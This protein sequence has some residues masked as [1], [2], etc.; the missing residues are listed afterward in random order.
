MK[1][2]LI[3]VGDMSEHNLELRR[4]IAGRI[5]AARTARGWTQDQL[6]AELGLADRQ[7]ISAI[8]SGERRV[9][10][11]ELI[12]AMAVFAR[13]MEYFTDPAMIVEDNYFS[14]RA[15]RSTPD[16]VVFESTARKLLE[17]NRRLRTVLSEVVP[18]TFVGLRGLSKSSGIEDA[19]A[20]GERFHSVLELGDRPATKL[21]QA[22]TSSYHILV[23]EINAP[24]NVSG[25]ACH[26]QDGDVIL[27]NI[28]EPSYRKNYTTGHEFFHLL[29]W[30]EMPPAKADLENVVG[31]KP[32]V[33][34]LADAF[35]GSLLMPAGLLKAVWDG[36][37]GSDEARVLHVARHFDVSGIAAYWRLV[38]T[39]LLRDPAREVQR[40]NIVRS[41]EPSVGVRFA[42]SFILRLHRALADGRISVNLAAGLMEMDRLELN[43]VFAEHGL[44][45]PIDN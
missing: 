18:P 10:A 25:A 8:E 13:P 27:L 43:E 2:G 33:E 41:E 28:T 32:K 16:I 44:E 39:R 36:S 14:Y 34:Q 29:T 12:R 21:R 1:R 40:G 15:Q 35:T 9:G 23:L 30:Q 6:A 45:S 4:T 19:A 5:R 7:T 26:L 24:A 20:L 3:V 11:D 17:L 37:T 38:N 42:G 22:I 31:Q